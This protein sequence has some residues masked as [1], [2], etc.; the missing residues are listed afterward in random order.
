[1]TFIL[2]EDEALR[3]LLK[4]MTV[5]DNKS[6]S[7]P[8]GVWFGQP[9]PE[10]REQSYPFVTIDLVDVNEARERVMNAAGVKPWYY[11]I[12]TGGHDDWSMPYPVPV[13]LDYQITTYARQPR[14]DRQILAQL[15]GTRLPLR[16]GSLK[17]VEKTVNNVGQATVRRLDT[18][19]IA[20]RDTVNSGKRLFMNM[21]TVRISS[22]IPRPQVASLFYK[23]QQVTLT[24]KASPYPTS[25][26]DPSL[27]Q[28]ITISI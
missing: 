9:D 18:I 6:S 8:V 13:N 16:Y 3:D 11:E 20:K 23:V 25:L 12:Q 21:F 24:G 14:H 26:V 10:V 27:T 28:T 19:E 7:R 22:E 5:A 15:L 1:M 17:V 2:S 4:G